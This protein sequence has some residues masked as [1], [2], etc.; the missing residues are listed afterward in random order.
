MQAERDRERDRTK[1]DSI[2][3][4]CPVCDTFFISWEAKSFGYETRRTDFR[5]NYEEPNPMRLYYHL[6]PCCKLCADQE[7]FQLELSGTQKRELA[8]CLR[9]LYSKYG[10]GIETSL[11]ARLYYGAEVGELL[12]YLGH[13]QE[14]PF[15][16]ALSFVQPFW[17]SGPEERA[18]YGK[19]A[20]KKLEE[21]LSKVRPHTEDALHIR[22]LMGEISRRLGRKREAKKHFEALLHLR[23]LRENE[24]NRFLFDLA[25]QQMTNPKDILPEESL[26]PFGRGPPSG[27]REP[28]RPPSGSA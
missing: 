28:P 23:P 15:D 12:Q 17:W 8:E 20:L 25:E 16:R 3:L 22:Y 6:C 13:I 11:P 1:M 7:Y 21:A 14:T 10:E 5:P 4:T 26:N 18:K 19:L 27:G 24:S 9:V 2:S